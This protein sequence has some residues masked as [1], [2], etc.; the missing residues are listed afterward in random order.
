MKDAS[1]NLPNILY[2][3]QPEQIKK[4]IEKINKEKNTK[5]SKNKLTQQSTQMKMEDYLTTYQQN[6]SRIDLPI[7]LNPQHA[8][9]TDVAIH[10][11]LRQRIAK[12]TII[13][14]MR[15][16]RFMENHACPINFRKPTY[17]NFIQHMD[18]REQ[19]DFKNGGGHGALKHE[20]Q[21]M[22][23]FLHAYGIP[24]WTYK[25]P[26][27][28]TYTTIPIPFPEQV[29]QILHLH[30]SDDAYENA[31]IQYILCH[32]FII[33]WRPPSEPTTIKI[34]DIKID[35]YNRGYIK[36]TEPKKHY[37]TRYLTPLEIM[38]NKRR[39]SFKNWI[40]CWRPKVANQH[41]QDYLYLKPNGKPF[42]PET[43]RMYLNRKAQ[44]QIKTIFPEY[45]NYT[46]RHFCAIARL[47]RTKIQTH[48]YD[49]YEVRDWLGHTKIETTMNYLKDA[50]HY[51][52]LAPYDW[53][54]RA[55]KI[56]KHQNKN[57]KE[58]QKPR[59]KDSFD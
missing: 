23:M 27:A 16:A 39:K 45:Y 8:S 21:T 52:Q 56:T 20:W 9:F 58:N 3:I 2:K 31:L 54:H 42:T 25:P 17:K 48:H 24:Q 35:N 7:T 5:K 11:L 30:Y 38:T 40:D 50:K 33:G 47:I 14:N 41:S 57:H 19:I 59:K 28:P 12:G 29:N 1:Q 46:S 55:L 43:L 49:A 10:A 15:Y 53:I 22:K 13:R 36:I 44:P 32:N 26:S 6:I 37:S 34:T 4:D 18:Y 51:Y